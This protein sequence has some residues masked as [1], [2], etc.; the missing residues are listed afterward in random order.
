MPCLTPEGIFFVFI[1]R[2]MISLGLILLDIYIKTGDYCVDHT[3]MGIRFLISSGMTLAFE[4][5]F[6]G[7][8]N[9]L[10]VLCIC[11]H[12]FVKMCTIWLFVT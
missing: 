5:S 10:R 8:C 9:M 1:Y 11:V 12:E 3:I 6:L 2:W 7:Q 4:D